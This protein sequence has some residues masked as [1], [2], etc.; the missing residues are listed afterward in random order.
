MHFQVIWRPVLWGLTIQ[1]LLGLFVLRTYPGYVLFDWLNDVF[2]K[3]FGF[4]TAGV[5][6][7]F[8]ENYGEHFFA[9]SV[10]FIISKYNRITPYPSP[11]R[12][13]RGSRAYRLP[14]CKGGL[15]RVAILERRYFGVFA[16]GTFS[17]E[18]LAKRVFLVNDKFPIIWVTFLLVSRDRCSG[19]IGN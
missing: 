13:Q 12:M 1:F 11:P 15:V 6:F 18:S 7:V 17:R 9:L 19:D 2:V 16:L 3:L 5:I 14:E 4:S 8:G 10:S